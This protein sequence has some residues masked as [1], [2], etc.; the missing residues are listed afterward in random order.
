MTI[1]FIDIVIFLAAGQALLL[2][3]LIFHKHHQ[4][5]ANRFLALM[6]L[7]YSLILV[8][9]I[10]WEIGIYDRYPHLYPQI[11]GL[12]FLI[13]P[14]HYLYARF[15]ITYQQHLKKTD[16]LHFLPFLF[17]QIYL[18]RY[19]FKSSDEI[20]VIIR[21][22]ETK[23][24]EV[25]FI[26]YDWFIIVQ[27]SLYLI[28]TL[29]ILYRYRRKIKNAFSSLDKVR[30]NWLRNIT[31]LAACG[32]LVYL[33]ENTLWLAGINLTNYN[34]SSVIIA[35]Y[36]YSMGYLGLTKVEVFTRP[37]ISANI[38]QVMQFQNLKLADGQSSVEEKKYSKSGLSEINA[39]IY[40]Q[41]LIEVM[42]NEKLYRD[43][44]LTLSQ[45]AEFVGISPHNLSE[46]L[47]TQLGENFFDFINKY[48]V[49]EAKKNL[50]DPQKQNLK[51][52]TI[53]L[54]AGFNSKTA[55]NTIFKKVTGLTPSSYR[56]KHVLS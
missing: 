34:L 1:D 33:L 8:H 55:F 9:L 30:L 46:V 12:A 38:L 37:E 25:E 5:Y 3:F 35:G 31:Y 42:E 7:A 53:A 29:I 36:V 40:R 14:L 18:G 56:Q 32:M 43:S 28:L 45:L 4:L 26:L 6:L 21:S 49:D 16:W 47:N 19:L 23:T 13:G 22:M 51:I 44:N 54:E 39:K 17:Y 24:V 11:M 15:L 41:K 52:L 50:T 10:L 48:R 20:M 2:S 27:G